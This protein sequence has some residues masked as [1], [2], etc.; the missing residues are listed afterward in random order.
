MI[1]ADHALP[2]VTIIKQVE[3]TYLS[4][5]LSEYSAKALPPLPLLMMA[6]T[7]DRQPAFAY[8]AG[9]AGQLMDLEEL[10]RFCCLVAGA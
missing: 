6:L 2:I 8:T 9:G 10:E 7:S 1:L 4:W 5:I 3:F